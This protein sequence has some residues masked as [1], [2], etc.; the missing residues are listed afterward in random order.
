MQVD[1][2]TIRRCE[3]AFEVVDPETG[4]TTGQLTLGEVFEQVLGVFSIT[5]KAY[6]MKTAEQWDEER[7]ARIERADQ[8]RKE[9]KL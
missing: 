2:V 8:R 1:A 9:E 7:R 4:A 6:P 5:S 3:G